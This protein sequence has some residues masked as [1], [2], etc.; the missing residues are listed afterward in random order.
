MSSGAYLTGNPFSRPA[1]QC[2]KQVMK[3]WRRRDF[4]VPF[5]LARIRG[6][7][8]LAGITSFLDEST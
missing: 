5:S 6:T 1:Q 3:Y 8:P 4:K 7:R 2:N